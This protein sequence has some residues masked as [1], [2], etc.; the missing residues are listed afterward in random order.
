MAVRPVGQRLSYCP[1]R[2]AHG[3]FMWR[4]SLLPSVWTGV[5]VRWKPGYGGFIR[6]DLCWMSWGICSLRVMVFPISRRCCLSVWDRSSSLVRLVVQ[7]KVVPHENVNCC[8]DE[9]N[10]RVTPWNIHAELRHASFWGVKLVKVGRRRLLDNRRL[11]C[12]AP[13]NCLWLECCE[14]NWRICEWTAL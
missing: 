7:W 10:D 9:W 4:D 8:D 11:I 5:K 3:I 6:R 13:I 2:R 1:K 14:C 12:R